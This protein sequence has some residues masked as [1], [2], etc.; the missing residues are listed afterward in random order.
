MPRNSEV[1]QYPIKPTPN[2]DLDKSFFLFINHR[3]YETWLSWVY[4]FLGREMQLS[5]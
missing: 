2:Y 1:N 4:F 5:G 3:W